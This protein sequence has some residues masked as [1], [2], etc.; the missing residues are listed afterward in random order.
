MNSRCCRMYD[1]TGGAITI[2]G[3]DIRDVN[4][5]DLRGRVFGYIDQEPILFSTSIMENIRYGRED[6]TDEEVTEVAKKANAHEFITNFPRGY[7]TRVG[8]C[9]TLL[10]GG[11]KQ[12]VAIARALLKEP[13]ILILDEA[14]R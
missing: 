13:S 1:V 9:G 5:R 12:R 8:E 2:D 4:S 14:T 11:Q 7:D 6:A 3:M 10:S